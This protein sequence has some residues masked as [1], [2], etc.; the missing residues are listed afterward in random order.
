MSEEVDIKEKIDNWYKENSEKLRKKEEKMK[1]LV[2][3]TDYIDWLSS[4]LE[5]KKSFSD[6][7]WMYFLD[8][9]EDHDRLNMAKICLLYETVSG[10]ALKN[11]INLNNCD[12]GNYYKVVYN[13]FCFD[14]GVRLDHG[15]VFFC[16]I[17]TIKEN[18]S[19]I[20]FNN[21]LNVQEKDKELIK[22]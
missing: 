12:Y 19:V 17:D 2:S 8:M 22:K 5:D 15:I 14:V 10:Y 1:E 21:I 4:F 16:N 11:N 7:D 9:F 18:D 13:D 20:D 6:E 3:S